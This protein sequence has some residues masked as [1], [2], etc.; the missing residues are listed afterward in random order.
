MLLLGFNLTVDFIQ[1][2]VRS[3]ESQV[4]RKMVYSLQDYQMVSSSIKGMGEVQLVDIPYKTRIVLES[5]SVISGQRWIPCVPHHLS[6]IEVEQL[7]EKMP[8]TLRER[9]L[10]FQLEGVRYGLRRG[11]R[12]LIADEMGLGKTI[13]VIFS[14]FIFYWRS[15][16]VTML[17]DLWWVVKL[18]GRYTWT[19]LKLMCREELFSACQ[20]SIKAHSL[21][22]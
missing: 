11:G 19:F 22:S 1:L 17:N 12:C 13:Q 18:E 8:S 9:L 15:K 7:I 20:N 16:F 3:M 2:S 6:D 14:L 5:F 10:P 21:F 4:G